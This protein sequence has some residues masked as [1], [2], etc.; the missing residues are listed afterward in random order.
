MMRW[1]LKKW[2]TNCLASVKGW[3][4]SP[5]AGR[6][7]FRVTG[8]DGTSYPVRDLFDLSNEL[9]QAKRDLELLSKCCL[10]AQTNEGLL[11]ARIGRFQTAHPELH[12]EFF[13]VKG[14][15]KR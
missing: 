9:V 14:K 13:T 15:V 11:A 2:L 5:V 10:D 12:A 4:A 6:T 8:A 1:K 3:F 7:E